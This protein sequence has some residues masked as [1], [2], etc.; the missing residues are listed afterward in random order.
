VYH[1]DLLSKLL[2]CNDFAGIQKAVVD[3]ISSRPPNSDHY[4]FLVQALIWEALWSVFSGQSLS[5]SLL[6]VV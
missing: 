6:A 3:Q 1:I 4:L 2:R 5:W